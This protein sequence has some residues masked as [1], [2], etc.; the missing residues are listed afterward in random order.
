LP[1]VLLQRHIL[2]PTVFSSVVMFGLSYL[3]HGVVLK[4]LDEMSIPLG[5]YL[6]LAALIYLVIGL[7]FTLVVHK[8]IEHEWISLKHGFPFKCL[9]LGAAGGFLVYLLVFVLG[10]SYA[11]H[12]MVHVVAD[13]VWQMAEQG[14]GGLAVSGGIIYDLHKRFLEEERG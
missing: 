14:L 7:C 12:G 9:L 6:V 10:F 13:V 5:V 3:W 1:P 8:A 4:D 2:M 11:A